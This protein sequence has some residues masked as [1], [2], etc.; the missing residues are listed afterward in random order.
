MN[1][2][3]SFLEGVKLQ[4]GASPH[5]ILSILVREKLEEEAAF[6]RF[7]L[8]LADGSRLDASERVELIGER[9]VITKY[10]FHWQDR[11]GR[12]I[13]RWDTA[14]HHL[15]LPTFPHHIH[16]GAEENIQPHAPVTLADVLATIS[17]RLKE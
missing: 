16:D 14:P 5:V 13:A 12:L 11:D 7:R 10:S 6:Y 1:S 8:L 2:P 17:R 15:T 9:L 4:I 3:E